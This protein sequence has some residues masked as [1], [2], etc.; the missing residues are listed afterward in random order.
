MHFSSII[1]GLSLASLALAGGYSG[2]GKCGAIKPAYAAKVV[3][4]FTTDGIIPDLIEAPTLGTPK[5][6]VNAAYGTKKVNLGTY[7]KTLETVNAPSIEFTGEAKYDPK[8]T[9][10]IIFL[11]DPDVPFNGAPGIQMNF[12]HLTIAD[13]QPFCVTDTR[14]TLVIYEPLTPASNTQH[15]Y[16]FLVYRQPAD[17]DSGDL[18][19]KA[20]LQVRTPFDL[21]DFAQDNKL[22]LVGGNFLKEAATNGL[23]SPPL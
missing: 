20:L 3:S 23:Q 6:K 12:N 22:K 19:Q 18:V 17:F 11:V 16:T 21:N 7:F 4:Q 1:S 14:K 13:A 15:R 2:A 8:T 9:K 10:Y 5:V